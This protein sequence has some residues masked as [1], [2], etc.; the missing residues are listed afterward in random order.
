MRIS[1]YPSRKTSRNSTP[2][3][4]PCP[5]AKPRSATPT[6]ARATAGSNAVPSASSPPQPTC[7]FRTFG[8]L[9]SSNATSPTRTAHRDPP[10][11]SSASPACRPPTPTRPGWPALPAD[12]GYRVTALAP[13]H[14]LSRRRIPDQNQIRTPHHGRTPQPRHRSNP[15]HRTNRHHRHNPMGRPLH[16]PPTRTTPNHTTILKRPRARQPSNS[17]H[18]FHQTCVAGKFTRTPSRKVP[19][20]I[21]APPGPLR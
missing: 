2:R 1:A 5:G 9:P 20:N 10:S 18:R 3:S 16:A 21:G 19:P 15:P 4:T 8:K 17:Y 6:P 11:L 12:T 13:R 7:R 14:P